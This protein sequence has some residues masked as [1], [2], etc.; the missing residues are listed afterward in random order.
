MLNTGDK[1]KVVILRRQPDGTLSPIPV[2]IKDIERGRAKEM[3]FIVPGDQI[4]VPGNKL[5]AIKGIMDL[6]SIVSFARLFTGG[7]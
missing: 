4:I 3:A 1:S 5:K 2:N 7:W 6:M